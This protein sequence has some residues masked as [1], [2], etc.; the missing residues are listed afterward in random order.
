MSSPDIVA[1]S[2]QVAK[3]IVPWK[4]L[5]TRDQLLALQKCEAAS[6]IP[7]D[8]PAELIMYP[9]PPPHPSSPSHS[10]LSRSLPP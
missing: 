6:K 1:G 7:S 4:G 3:G 10:S 8:I 5:Y 9:S 2:E